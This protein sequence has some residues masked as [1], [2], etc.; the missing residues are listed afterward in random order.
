MLEGKRC[1]VCK[2]EWS[3]A[4]LLE[5]ILGPQMIIVCEDCAKSEGIP[6]IKKPTE[7]QINVATERKS[8]RERME[9]LSGINNGKTTGISEDQELVQRNLHKL[10]SPTHKETNPFVIENHYW[11]AN[12]GRRRKKI[13]LTQAAESLDVDPDLL[14]KIE[15]GKIPENFE[16]IFPKMERLYG[17]RLLNGRI[18][19]VQFVKTIEEE[20]KILEEVKERMSEDK[21][22]LKEI[23]KGERQSRQEVHRKIEEGEIDFSDK[24]HLKEITLNDL[25]EMKDKKKR[26]EEAKRI[27]GEIEGMVGED[28]ELDFDEDDI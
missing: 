10:K 5:G 28:L 4:K 14:E 15:H 7:A 3:E 8:V 20:G 2:K 17:I 16:E 1:S 22:V 11:I 19:K 21:Q 13:T 27:R 9:R 12:M 23:K 18:Q 25:V 6:T 26:I 24:E